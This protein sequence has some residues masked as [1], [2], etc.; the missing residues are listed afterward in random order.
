MARPLLLPFVLLLPGASLPAA[1]VLLAGV[2]LTLDAP[3]STTVVFG[4]ELLPGREGLASGITLGLAVG[5]GGLIASALGVIAD[6]TS[7]TTALYAIA[8]L[9]V[10]SLALALTLPRGARPGAHV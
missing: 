3:F 7:L 2:G 10:P 4:Q 9:L 5:L 8:L 1:L 6:A